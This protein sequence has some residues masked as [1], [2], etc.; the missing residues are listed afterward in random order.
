MSQKIKYLLFSE[1]TDWFFKEGLD[2]VESCSLESILAFA[3]S[4]EESDTLLRMKKAMEVVRIVFLLATCT[5]FFGMQVDKTKIHAAEILRVLSNDPGVQFVGKM[6][7]KL[8]FNSAITYM[9]VM[10]F[11]NFLRAI[12]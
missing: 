6:L 12:A 11:I 10:K 3:P 2:Q 1:T 4:N 7:M 8:P 9:P 5:N